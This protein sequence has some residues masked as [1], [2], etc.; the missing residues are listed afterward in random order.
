MVYTAQHEMLPRQTPDEMARQRFVLAL[1]RHVMGGLRA[2]VVTAYEAKCEPDFV[3]AH[4]RE[5]ETI[6]E[7]EG[8][9]SQSNHYRFTKS[10]NRASQEMMWQSVAETVYREKDRISEASERILKSNDRLGTLTLDPNFKPEEIYETCNIHLQP[11]GYCPPDQGRG[12]V[13]A[14][15]FYESGGRLYSMGRGMN[16]GDSKAGSVLRWLKANR[17][18]FQPKR[19]L[20]MGCSAGGASAVY[21]EAFPQAE[22]HACDL[23]ASMLRYAHTRAEAM[24]VPVHFHQMDAANTSFPDG[25]FDL[26]VSHNLAHEIST[27]K[28]CELAKETL[29][30][31][32][33]GGIAIHQDVDLLFRNK[34]PWEMAERLYDLHHNNEP[35]WADYAYCDFKSELIDAGFDADHVAEGAIPNTSGRGGWYTFRAWKD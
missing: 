12:D 32:A 6:E 16:K 9:L 7:A 14:G 33:P 28:R 4:G 3:E 26:I 22:V 30:L 2:G 31:L 11:E 35:F 24:G 5:P 34:K 15:A 18:D 25:H 10:I 21:P 27:A 23:G 8:A 19:M 20:D 13:I 17:P 29:R 1:K